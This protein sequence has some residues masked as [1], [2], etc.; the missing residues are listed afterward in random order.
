M[1][2]YEISRQVKECTEGKI[3]ISEGALYPALHKLEAAGVLT[4]ETI[5]IGKRQ[6][7]YYSITEEGKKTSASKIK[8][9]SSFFQSLNQIMHF[10]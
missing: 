10:R 8:E 1:Y 7:K 5:M 6:R 3:V 9:L 4:T 2:G